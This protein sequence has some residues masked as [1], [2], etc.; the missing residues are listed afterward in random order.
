M[1]SKLRIFQDIIM[2]TDSSEHI[3]I[4]MD[5]KSK[6]VKHCNAAFLSIFMSL[7][8]FDSQRWMMVI[9][10][11]EFDFSLKN[12]SYMSRE[13]LII[14]LERFS[15]D[16]FHFKSDKSSSTDEYFLVLPAFISSSASFSASS[17][18][19]CKKYSGKERAFLG[20]LYIAILSSA[21]FAV[22]LYSDIS[23]NNSSGMSIV[24]LY[25]AAI[26]NFL[27]CFKIIIENYDIASDMRHKNGI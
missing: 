11:K 5:F 6:M 18:S 8:F 4:S 23:L 27:F 20:S 25:V 24:I 7:H 13:V 16:Y 10:N 2:R 17:Q 19:K 1:N 15:E 9:L 3:M 12:V 26:V 22:F 21:I 14:S